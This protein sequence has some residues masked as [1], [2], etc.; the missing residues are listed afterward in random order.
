M[1]IPVTDLHASLIVLIARICFDF[2]TVHHINI[3]ITVSIE[4]V[5]EF[6]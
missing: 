2:I 6:L 4:I 1:Q 5:I 3:K